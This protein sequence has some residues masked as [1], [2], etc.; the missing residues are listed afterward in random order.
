MAARDAALDRKKL[1]SSMVPTRK[2]AP[3]T[4]H[5]QLAGE[6]A[7]QPHRRRADADPSCGIRT[8]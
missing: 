6:P 7:S 3:G 4:E 8:R 5:V 2:A 1:A